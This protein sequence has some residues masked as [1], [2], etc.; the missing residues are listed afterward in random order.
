[1][2]D[3][4]AE[5]RKLEGILL[6]HYHRDLHQDHRTSAELTWNTFRDHLILEYEVPKYDPDLGSPNFFVRLDAALASAKV[7]NLIECFPSQR[8]RHWFEEDTFRGLLRLR[9][10]QAG[11]IAAE[12]F[13]AR[14]FCA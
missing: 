13:Y 12:G 9:G 3:L 11:A 14:K 4:R 6:T 8:H 5:G 10:V 2:D 7:R 1:M